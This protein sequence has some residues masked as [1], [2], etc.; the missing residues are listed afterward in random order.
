MGDQVG[1]FSPLG[2]LTVTEV[3]E[4]GHYLLLPKELIDKTP[5][6]GLCGSSDEEKFGFSYEVLDKYINGEIPSEEIKSKIDSMYKKGKFKIDILN[7]DTFDP[8][9]KRLF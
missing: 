6:D 3:K 9:I 5:A 8:G 2:K 7:I 4:I 1:S